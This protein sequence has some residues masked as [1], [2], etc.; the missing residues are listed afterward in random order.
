[1]TSIEM[2]IGDG[3]IWVYG[4]G[5]DGVQAFTTLGSRPSP[6]QLCRLARV[7]LEC[8]LELGQMVLT[9]DDLAVLGRFATL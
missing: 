9:F 3:V 4:V 7:I 1:M 2:E 8:V 6:S 5:E